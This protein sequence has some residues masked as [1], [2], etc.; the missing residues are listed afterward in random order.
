[1]A[2]VWFMTGGKRCSGAGGEGLH[3]PDREAAPAALGRAPAHHPV[4]SWHTGIALS[5][6]R[7]FD[8]FMEYAFG[9]ATLQ[10]IP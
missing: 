9:L 10:V 1:M 5:P 6:S 8:T 3:G 7:S 2:V 4:L